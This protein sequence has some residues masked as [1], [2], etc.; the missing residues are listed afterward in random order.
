MQHARCTRGGLRES[1]S[2][3]KEDVPQF[4]RVLGPVL[5]RLE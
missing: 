2:A 5:T 1:V 3:H 4:V